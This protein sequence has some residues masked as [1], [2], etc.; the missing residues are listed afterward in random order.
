VS[1]E[2]ATANQLNSGPG[3]IHAEIYTMIRTTSKYERMSDE[4]EAL[5]RTSASREFPD[6]YV[7]KPIRDIR[8]GGGVVQDSLT[9]DLCSYTVCSLTGKL[10]N[11]FSVDSVSLSGKRGP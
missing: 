5:Y 11:L 8:D 4:H 9:L 6:N 3:G 2:C 7:I 10:R 1:A